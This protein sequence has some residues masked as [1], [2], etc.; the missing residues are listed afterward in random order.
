MPTNSKIRYTTANIYQYQLAWCVSY[1][2]TIT[3]CKYLTRSKTQ[4][5]RSTN[6]KSSGKRF[7][8]LL[9]WQVQEQ[10]EWAVKVSKPC[11]VKIKSSGKLTSAAEQNNCIQSTLF[12]IT[13]NHR[14]HFPR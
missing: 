10:M 7:H 14:F 13:I 5:A 1:T 2:Q 4:T 6:E 11:L 3:Y 8:G 12:A 9:C